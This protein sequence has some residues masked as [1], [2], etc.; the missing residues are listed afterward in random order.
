MENKNKIDF[1]EF[2]DDEIFEYF[3]KKYT[4]EMG[5]VLTE[6]KKKFKKLSN[7]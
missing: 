4:K 5:T 1:K 6:A 3:N 2:I 7:N